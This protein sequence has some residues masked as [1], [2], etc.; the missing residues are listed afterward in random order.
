MVS[1]RFRIRDKSGIW[2]I[3][4]AFLASI[5]VRVIVIG[6]GLPGR[7][8]KNSLCPEEVLSTVLFV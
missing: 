4:R 3:S 1:V 6:G 5:M 8:Q 2:R 7:T